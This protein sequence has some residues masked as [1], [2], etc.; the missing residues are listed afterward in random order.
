MACGPAAEETTEVPEW[1]LSAEPSL[2]IGE[3]GTVEGELVRV[4]TALPLPGDEVAVVDAGH[5]EIRVF[6][7]T[8]RYQRTI[9]RR[10]QG[11]GEF[12]NILWAQ[13]AHD[14]LL[15]FDMN[16]RRL[17]VLGADGSVHATVLP[18]PEDGA[19]FAAPV[20]RVP[21][22]HW[23]VSNSVTAALLLGRNAPPPTGV[24]RDTVAFGLVDASGTGP[25]AYFHR[26][27]SRRLIGLPTGTYVSRFS[28][29]P[30]HRV[31]SLG[32]RI[33]VL[34]SELARIDLFTSDGLPLASAPLAVPRQPLAAST[35]DSLRGAALE[36]ATSP[37]DREVIAAIHDPQA[38]PTH[39][40]VFQAV[41]PDGDHLLWLEEWQYTPTSS[42][43]YQ[44]V[45]ADGES[46]A[47][48]TP[49]TGFKVLTVGPDW[50]L[51]VH[52]DADG[53]QRVVR[54]GLIRQ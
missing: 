18:R 28:R 19:T 26:V 7:G 53:V 15:V 40:P 3:D 9:G 32:G 46:L 38:A 30:P 16:Q 23:V 51:G 4:V 17:T 36:D 6:D 5:S 2:V 34:D 35:L 54:Y 52:T 44:V 20:A 48:V 41:L 27:A 42:A 14:T 29:L 25:V 24:L 21:G 45:N 8:G 39:L 31:L 13:L 12:A 37:L 1:T 22:G 11:P 49:P 10:G 47:T 50:V 43:S 33:A